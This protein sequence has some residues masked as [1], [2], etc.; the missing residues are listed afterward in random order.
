MMPNPGKGTNVAGDTPQEVLF[1]VTDGVEDELN[2][3][4][5]SQQTADR[6]QPLP[7][8]DQHRVVHDDQEPRHPASRF[9]T[10]TI[11]P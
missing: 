3:S 7:G 11:S 6:E 8:A 10:P 9:S 4:T 1:I 2:A 5:C